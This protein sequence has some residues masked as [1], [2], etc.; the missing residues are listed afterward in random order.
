MQLR[1]QCNIHPN[2]ASS[3]DLTSKTT[4]ELCEFLRENEIAEEVVTKFES[5]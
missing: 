3:A 2:M 1:V 4:K 5:K